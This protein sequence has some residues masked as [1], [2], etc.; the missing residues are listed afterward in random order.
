MNFTEK[1]KE[2]VEQIAAD[3]ISMEL[4]GSEAKHKHVALIAESI[5]EA[6]TA[7]NEECA[8]IADEWGRGRYRVEEPDRI[9][10]NI[11]DLQT[12]VNTT[13]RGIAEDIRSRHQPKA[14]SA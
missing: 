2:I 12:R 5:R 8:K 1:A 7:E 14:E 13:G 6:V 10:F 3:M 9:R 11:Y 4:S